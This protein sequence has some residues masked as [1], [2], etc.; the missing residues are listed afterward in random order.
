MISYIWIFFYDVIFKILYMEICDFPSIYM[1]KIRNQVQS[2][3]WFSAIYM[4]FEID[5]ER[6]NRCVRRLNLQ[7]NPLRGQKVIYSI[8]VT[9]PL[10]ACGLQK[11]PPEGRRKF[12][13][14]KSYIWQKV[15]KKHWCVVYQCLVGKPPFREA[16]EYRSICITLLQMR[17]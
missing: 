1:K 13:E 17:N 8:I 3:I 14:E 5:S 4:I 15:K 16:T 7:K 9:S 2:Y 11:M 6:W 10:I 12:L